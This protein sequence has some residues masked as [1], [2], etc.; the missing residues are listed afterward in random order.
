MKGSRET[1]S[2]ALG[3][4]DPESRRT[5]LKASCLYGFKLRNLKL[6]A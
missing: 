6:E 4:L 5:G 3:G 2:N 1:N